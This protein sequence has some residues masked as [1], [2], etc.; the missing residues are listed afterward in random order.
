[1]DY[2]HYRNNIAYCEEVPLQSIYEE[3]GSPTYVYSLATL[4][5]HCEKINNAF[6]TY[7]TLPCFAVKANSAIAYL[8]EIF[9][10]GYGADVVSVGELERCLL[11]GVDPS[12]VVFSGV[13][14]RRDEVKRALEVRIGS[15]NVESEFELNMLA[16]VSESLNLDVAISLRVNPD[17]DAKT[18][19]KITTGLDATKFG[20]RL[21]QVEKSLPFIKDHEHLNLVGVACHIGSQ[22]IDLSPLKEAVSFMTKF[23]TRLLS[24]D[25]PLKMI[26]M[27]GGL[28][29]KYRDENPPSLEE[30]ANVLIDGVKST[31][32]RLVIEPGRVVAGNTGVLLTSVIGVKST[33]SK[34]FIVLD[35]SMTE[36]VRPAF[37]D[38]YHDI[39]PVKLGSPTKV[40]NFDFVGPV[41]ESSD[42]LGLG[43]EL[44]T[45]EAGDLF[46]IRGCGAYGATMASNYNSRVRPMEVMVDG[47]SVRVIRQRETLEDLWRKEVF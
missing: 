36:F 12:K 39:D 44:A 41:C 3:F 26:N 2:F 9:A 10:S 18:N 14:K 5:R 37:Y 31:G 6:S 15:F 40:K 4:K 34:N 7:D 42:V 13:G 16:E 8:K 33:S 19:P 35:G 27:G 32:L 25:H 30:Y 21:G 24:E 20:M 46:F 22:M 47:E 28:G 43:R 11:A 23:A 45:P 17:I 29:I 38:S 1:V